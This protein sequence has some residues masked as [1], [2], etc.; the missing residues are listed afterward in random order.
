MKTSSQ[1]SFALVAFLLSGVSA[2]AEN[3][4]LTCWYNAGADFTSATP[5]ASGAALG[6]VEH[7]GRGDNTYSYTISARDETACPVQLPL[8]TLT[9]ETVA[10]VRQND[11]SCTNEKISDAGEAVLGGSVTV[12]RETEHTNTAG[13]RLAGVSPDTTYRVFVKCGRQLG[14]LRSDASGNAGRTFDYNVDI[15][16]PAYA[17]EIMPDGADKG[18]KLQSLT[19]KK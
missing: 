7:S 18:G 9:A 10:L 12:W 3:K 11:D 5:A 19:F 16:G 8:S 13:V 2:F 17:F 15:L 1:I 6:S 14:A 4:P